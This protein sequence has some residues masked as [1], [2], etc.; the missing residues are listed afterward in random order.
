MADNPTPDTE[1]PGVPEPTDDGAEATPAGGKGKKIVVLAAVLV[2]LVGGAGVAFSQF[3]AI[4]RTAQALFGPAGEAEE[5]DAPIEYGEFMQIDGLVVNPAETGGS[6]YLMVSLGL[7]AADAAVLEEV[8]LKD[9]VVRDAIIG[10]L[11]GK[12][13]ETLSDISTREGMKEEIRA[14]INGI[15]AEGEIDR[16]YFTQFMLQ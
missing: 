15:L 11:S 14:L 4:D 6:R 7:E 9:V 1:T 8:G 2:A 5:D 3:G 16:L 12:T 13:V 10:H